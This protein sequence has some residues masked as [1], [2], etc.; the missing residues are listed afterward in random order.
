METMDVGTLRP[1]IAWI[2]DGTLGIYPNVVL[3]HLVID[4]SA[5][6]KGKN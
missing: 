3:F 1:I 6:T 5:T 4:R 2:L